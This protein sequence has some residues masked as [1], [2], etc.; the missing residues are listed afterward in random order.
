MAF[1]VVEGSPAG[2]GAAEMV[3]P[4]GLA[5]IRYAER[6]APTTRSVAKI[7]AV[8]SGA[9]L[10][11]EMLDPGSDFRFQVPEDAEELVLEGEES[12]GG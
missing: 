3:R 5:P 4:V 11:A 7:S 2:I 9:V 8:R 1:D 6:A 12:A 10:S